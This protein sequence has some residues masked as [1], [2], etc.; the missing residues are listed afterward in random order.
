MQAYS[1]D[2]WR[3]KC[4]GQL[5]HLI[6]Y[7]GFVLG[8]KKRSPE[9][10]ARFEAM[11]TLAG[12]G[13]GANNPAFRQT[14][15]G[16]YIPG[17]TQEQMDYC[18]EL[19]RRCTSPECAVRIMDVLGEIDIADLLPKAKTPTLVMHLRDDAMVPFDQGKAMAADRAA[20]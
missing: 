6:L 2:V 19:Q 4:N 9:R 3:F 14:F 15:T 13:W 17:A 7:G 1:R 11:R 8:S 12:L 20:T 10:R 18:N 16:L 5:S